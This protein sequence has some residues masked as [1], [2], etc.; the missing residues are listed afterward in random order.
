M[1]HHRQALINMLAEEILM[2]YQQIGKLGLRATD[3]EM[4]V[5]TAGNMEVA[6]RIGYEL[7]AHMQDLRNFIRSETND[8]VWPVHRYDKRQIWPEE[9]GRFQQQLLPGMEEVSGFS[10]FPKTGLVNLA[11]IDGAK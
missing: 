7:A 11:I 5:L 3:W 8:T 10:A 1:L 2:L 9:R 4:P 6:L